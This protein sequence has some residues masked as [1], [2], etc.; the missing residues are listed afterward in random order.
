MK[1]DNLFN[2]SKISNSEKKSEFINNSKLEDV[3]LEDN[4]INSDLQY[5]TAKL[6][7]FEKTEAYNNIITK[8][9][10]ILDNDSY[11]YWSKTINYLKYLN[12]EF[13]YKGLCFYKLLLNVFLIS[14]CFIIFMIPVIY[15]F[16]NSSI[17]NIFLRLLIL[18]LVFFAIAYIIELLILRFKF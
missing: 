9:R 15:N 7:E 3:K 18:F 6:N 13:K 1:K 2:I 10:D 5:I 14:L 16:W 17:S 4:N 12:N 11:S 8:I